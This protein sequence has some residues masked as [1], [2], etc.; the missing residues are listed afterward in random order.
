[1][2]KRLARTLRRIAHQLEPDPIKSLSI[3]ESRT[4]PT[5]VDIELEWGQRFFGYVDSKELA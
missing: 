1:M 2:K 3:V 4:T 5:H